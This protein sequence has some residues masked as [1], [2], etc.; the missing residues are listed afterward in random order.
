MAENVITVSALIEVSDRSE[1]EV[2]E[3]EVPGTEVPENKVPGTEVPENNVNSGSDT[4]EA[5]NEPKWYCDGDAWV[6]LFLEPI[7][8]GK[9]KQF[10]YIYNVPGENE[11]PKERWSSEEC[12][13]GFHIT[14]RK[15]VYCHLPL[16]DYKSAYIAE[17]VSMGDE[18]YDSPYQFKR[19]VRIVTFGPAVPL[20]DVLGKHPNDFKEGHMLAWSAANNHIELVKLAAFKNP[21]QYNYGWAFGLA[22]KN[23]NDQIADFLFET[24]KNDYLTEVMLNCAIACGRSDFVKRMME[25]TPVCASFFRSA[26]E[27][28]QFE[29]FQLL[30]TWYGEPKCS[31]IIPAALDGGNV[32]ILDYIKSRGVDMSDF[33]MFVYAC[34]NYVSSI[35]TVKYLISA[36]ADVK[37]PLI[38]YIAKRYA[39]DEVR[40]YLLTQIDDKSEVPWCER[41]DDEFGQIRSTFCKRI[42]ADEFDGE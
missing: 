38:A 35:E 42:E 16:H 18:F 40:E 9:F 25:T 2:P 10:D 23:G 6:K 17:V 34:T 33:E 39:T 26:S 28:G 31:R 30:R 7:A 36:G 27:C 24:C 8:P 14:R 11:F 1:N 4:A 19:K 32:N 21:D 12:I 22:L 3:N 37:H 13:N 20:A 5:Q 41:L 29:I 15:D